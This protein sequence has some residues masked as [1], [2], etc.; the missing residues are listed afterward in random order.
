MIVAR[1]TNRRAALQGHFRYAANLRAVVGAPR[2]FAPRALLSIA[3]QVRAANVMVMAHFRA[4]KAREIAFGLVGAS[5]VER[6][7]LL[8]IDALHF[9]LGMQAIP[10][11]SL[12]SVDQR[13][14]FDA[15]LD[16][17][18]RRAFRTEHGGD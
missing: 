11:R 7:G 14:Q 5:A 10:A 6:V 15:G 8:V 9:V 1:E 17:C 18:E 13:S 16:P 3:K 12:V 4:A 2:I